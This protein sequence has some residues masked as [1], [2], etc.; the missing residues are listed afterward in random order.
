MRNK[1]KITNFLLICIL[2]GMVLS[3]CNK[4]EEPYTT[5]ESQRNEAME[6]DDQHD[7]IGENKSGDYEVEDERFYKH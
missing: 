7:W 2:V 1:G 5:M 4:A 6:V 3:G